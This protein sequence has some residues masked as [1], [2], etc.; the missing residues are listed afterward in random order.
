MLSRQPGAGCRRL[1]VALLLAIAA[2]APETGTDLGSATITIV[3][4]YRSG[5]GF[6]RS[7]RAFAPYFARELGAGATVLPE[8]VPGAG[9]RRGATKVYRSRPDGT[10]LGIFNLPGFVLP[11]VLGEKVD[12]DLREL[13]WIGRLESQFYV[14]LVA[15][16]GELQSLEDIRAAREIAFLSTGYGSTALAASQIA[17]DRL[18]LSDPSPVFLAGYA[19]TADYLVGLI[20]GDGN[21]ALAPVSSAL[22]YIQSGDLRPLAVAGPDSPLDGVPTFASLGFQQLAR[23]DLQRSIAGPPGIDAERLALIRAAFDRAVLNP[24]FQAAARR[25]RLDLSPLDGEATAAEVMASY[26]FYETFRTNLKNPN[27]L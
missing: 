10:M 9:G 8:N 23:L 2:C 7:V 13:S 14:L 25:A 20:R 16:A 26:T 15:A 21:V 19:G 27:A 17:A 3:V 5:G 4:P 22:K 6:D 18:G 12:Y 11:E 24:E 1:L